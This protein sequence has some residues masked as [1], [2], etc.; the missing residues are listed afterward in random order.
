MNLCLLLVCYVLHLTS[1]LVILFTGLTTTS[2]FVLHLSSI[3]VFVNS[4]LNRILYCW[5]IKE[6]KEIVT[7]NINVLQLCKIRY[8]SSNRDCNV[9]SFLFLSKTVMPAVI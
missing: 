2:R 5:R 3:A 1:H 8:I 9:R 6:I 4:S 7:A